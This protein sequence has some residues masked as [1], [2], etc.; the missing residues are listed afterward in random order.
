MNTFNMNTCVK[1]DFDYMLSRDIPGHNHDC[2]LIYSFG[3]DGGPTASI[4]HARCVCFAKAQDKIPVFRTSLD[5]P[6]RQGMLVYIE[7]ENRFY[8]L[9]NRVQKDVDCY[10]TKATPCNAMI[11]F[12]EIIPLIVDECG[13]LVQ[14]ETKV[15]LIMGIPCVVK[16]NPALFN[17]EAELDMS[18]ELRVNL[19][20]NKYTQTIPIE[21]RF[22]L[23]G[24]TYTVYSKSITGDQQRTHGIIT[25]SCK[26]INGGMI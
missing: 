6:I 19:Q 11:T 7:D 26:P 10:S 1:D 9:E 4:D 3:V 23:D 14:E 18:D 17:G 13:L 24:Q 8:L 20:L 2:D 25:L 16:S 5:Y 12:F 22:V 15:Y 21:A